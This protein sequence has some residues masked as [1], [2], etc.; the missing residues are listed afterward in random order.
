MSRTRLTCSPLSRFL[1][2]QQ[3]SLLDAQLV[4]LWYGWF[5]RI[6]GLLLV[7]LSLVVLISLV[8][9]FATNKAGQLLPL[10]FVISFIEVFLISL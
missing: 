2:P 7:V 3:K 9:K 5:S 6:M 8:A 4:C 10:D 1:L